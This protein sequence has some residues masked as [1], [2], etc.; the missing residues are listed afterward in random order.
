MAAYR[1]KMS[2]SCKIIPNEINKVNEIYRAI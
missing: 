1:S 2:F